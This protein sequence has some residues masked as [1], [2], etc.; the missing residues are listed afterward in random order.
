MPAVPRVAVARGHS[1]RR[2]PA[3]KAS[4]P[5]EPTVT[6]GQVHRQ[7]RLTGADHRQADGPRAGCDRNL[8]DAQGARRIRDGDAR[9]AERPAAAEREVEPQAEV[10]A[11]SRAR[12]SARRGRP[13]RGTDE[14][15]SPDRRHR[16]RVDR[17]A[18]LRR[19]QARRAFI[20]TRSRSS[21]AGVTCGPN[22]HHRIITR[23]SSGGASNS[24]ASSASGERPT[25]GCAC[26]Q[27]SV[28]ATT[29]ATRQGNRNVRM[30][31]M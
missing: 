5:A 23:A 16:G 24:R 7:Q 1:R 30:C 9:T 19:R 21:P 12:A 13:A 14:S 3:L 28:V 15:V 17:P 8:L 10:A 11:R 18:A 22:H 27:P 4:G 6:S 2:A 29:S 26:S 20:A 25:A 31:V